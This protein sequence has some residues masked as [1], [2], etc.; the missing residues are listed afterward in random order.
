MKTGVTDLDEDYTTDKGWNSDEGWTEDGSADTT[1][2]IADKLTFTI[3]GDAD[4]AASAMPLSCWVKFSTD[5]I[6]AKLAEKFLSSTT[7]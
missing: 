3:T 2:G 7:L 5:S 4:L 6:P 1:W